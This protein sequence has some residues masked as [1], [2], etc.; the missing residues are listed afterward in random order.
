MTLRSQLKNVKIQN[1]ETIQK[2]F[3][4]VSQIK[5]QLEAIG[6]K[7]EEA[8]FV[9]TTLNGLPRAWDS[10][11]QGICSRKELTEFS[12]LWEDCTQEEARIAA[13]E[14][15]MG[16]DDNQALTTRT[17]KGK[18]KKEFHS[19]KKFQKSHKSHQKKRDLI[20]CFSCQKT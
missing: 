20:R 3:S 16:D 13:R 12:N 19:P 15:K 4:R 9:M 14:E 2:Y 10:F 11:I 5:E 8:E 18:G 7:V 1:S 17:R 6:D